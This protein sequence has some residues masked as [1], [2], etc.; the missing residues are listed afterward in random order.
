MALN[1][2]GQ[3]ILAGVYG[4]RM[5][6]SAN[7]GSSWSEIRPDGD[8]D[9]N[10]LTV[11]L[12]KDGQTML[13]GIDDAGDEISPRNGKLYLSQDGGN[14][15]SEKVLAGTYG[16]EW[17]ISSISDDGKRMLVGYGD[18]TTAGRIFLS[19]NSG[20]TWS[21]TQPAGDADYLWKAGVLS[22]DGYTMVVAA[23]TYSA[24]SRM[25]IG[26]LP[27]PG[28]VINNA[29]PPGCASTQP[30]G[31]PDLFQIDTTSD[32]AKLYFTPV[33]SNADKYVISFGYTP[34]DM[35]FGAELSGNSTGVMS[36][37]INALSPSSTYYVRVRAGN[38][39]ATGEWSNEMK[40]TTASKG[41]TS[42]KRFFENFP[43]QIIF[44]ITHLVNF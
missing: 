15:W 8:N 16:R 12:D 3:I 4:G 33:S 20:S 24:T 37:T 17:R 30:G 7:Q 18:S 41:S 10:W 38:G 2:N 22:G 34:G 25:Y 14:S 43:S 39:C 5:Y 19:T 23:G 21:E 9:Y 28:P 42:G 1:D 32:K 11:G 40:F 27:R 29:Q 36:Y 13:V 44:L 35:R 26:T 31:Q 6:R